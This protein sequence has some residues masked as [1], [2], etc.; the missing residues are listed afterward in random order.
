MTAVLSAL[1]TM[2]SIAFVGW[3]LARTGVLGENVHTA[4]AKVVFAVAAPALLFVTVAHADLDLLL[5]RSALVAALSTSAVAIIA[6]VVLR[7]VVRRSLVEATVGMLCAAYV[8]AAILG[9]PLAV[10]L[11]GD[12]LAVVPV[13][14]FQLIVLAPVGFTVLAAHASG[15]GGGLRG[16]AGRTF[17]NPIIVG[18]LTGLLFALLPWRL[19]EVVFAP[20]SMVGAAAAPLA[21]LTFGMSMHTPRMPRLHRQDVDREQTRRPSADLVL[22]L[23]LRTAVHPLIA[24]GIGRAVGMSGADLLAVVTMGALPTAQNILV[25]AIQYGRGQDLARNSGLITTLLSV[26]LLLAVNALLG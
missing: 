21:L 10:Y 4:L 15:G 19:P 3:L 12:A 9:L 22:V 2:I 20:F 18:A 13:L 16:M 11:L 5:S 8:N 25:Y 6:V 23:V 26:P 1:G 7:L 14:L 24:Y 17:R